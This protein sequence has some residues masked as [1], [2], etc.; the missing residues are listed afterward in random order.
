MRFASPVP[1]QFNLVHSKALPRSWC[2]FAPLSLCRGPS[3][4]VPITVEKNCQ[5]LFAVGAAPWR[6][7][8]VNSLLSLFLRRSISEMFTTSHLGN[9]SAI[10][11]LCVC[12]LPSGRMVDTEGK[13]KLCRARA[14]GGSYVISLPKRLCDQLA[15]HE[16]HPG[17]TLLVVRAIGPVIVIS[18]VTDVSTPES[19]IHEADQDLL[20]ALRAWQANGGGKNEK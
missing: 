10:V 1:H 8:E 18:R 16:I 15:I 12:A 6:D 19:A 7:G 2:V 3:G 17:M 13:F 5:I 4:G 11:L 20:A 9:E 14:S